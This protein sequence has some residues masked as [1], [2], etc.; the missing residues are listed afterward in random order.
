MIMRLGFH[1][2]IAGGIPQVLARAVRR[3][4]TTLQL[5]TSSPVQWARCPLDPDECRHFAQDLAACD[6]RPH[7][8]HASY[9][10][11][12]ASPNQRLWRRSVAH[13]STELRRAEMLCAAGVVLHLGSAQEAGSVNAGIKRVAAGLDAAREQANNY[14][15]LILENS[16]GAGNT[17]GSGIPEI[18]EIIAQSRYADHLQICLDTAHAFAAGWPLHTAEGLD[19][20][21]GELDSTCSPQRLVLIHANDSRSEFASRVDRHWHIGK[22]KIGREAF[23]TIVNHPRLHELPFIMETPGTERDDLR[24]MRVIRRLISKAIRPPLPPVA[25]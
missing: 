20:V 13:L 5:F 23:R 9:L 2:S 22:G 7:F 19:K 17:V 11:N 25:R 8:V 4:C 10:L 16:A 3:R 18:A 14:L 21:L 12:I 15:P 6:I 24:N 1:V